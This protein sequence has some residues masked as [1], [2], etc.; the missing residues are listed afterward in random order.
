MCRTKNVSER[1]VIDL[2]ERD[3]YEVLKRGWPDLIA[4]K[5][6]KVRLI[7]VKRKYTSSGRISKSELKP[8]QKR[9][10]ELLFKFGIVIE[11]IRA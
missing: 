3:G 9:V 6:D 7:E 5:G 8:H 2:L 10:A 11:V 4:V 1:A